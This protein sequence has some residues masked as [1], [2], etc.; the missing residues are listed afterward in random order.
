MVLEAAAVVAA[1]VVPAAHT[2]AV[3]VAVE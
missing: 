1:A 2:M 3:Q